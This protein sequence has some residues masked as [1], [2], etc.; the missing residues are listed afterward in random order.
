[1]KGNKE[2]SKLKKLPKL[3]KRVG[4]IYVKICD[5]KNIEKAIRKVCS[6][7]NA[8]RSKRSENGNAKKQKEK[9]LGNISY[10]TKMIQELL[11]EE[12]YKPK[13]LRRKEIF[14]GV[15]HKKRI[16]AKP[17]MIDKIVQNAVMQIIEPILTRHMYMYSCASIKKKGGTYC[18]RMIERAI[19]RKNR[20][21]KIYKNV[22]NTKYWIALDVVKFYDNILHCFL[23]FRLL[24]LFKDAKVLNLLFMSIDVYNVKITQAGKRGIPIGTPFGHWFANI[25][26]TPVDFVVKHIFKVKYM[27]RYAD[28]ILLF[29]SNKRKLKQQALFLQQALSRIG[30]S[31][32]SKLQVHQTTDKTTKDNRP[33]DFIGY[34]YYRDCTTLRSSICLRI[35]RRVRKV[36][37]KN[38]LNGHDARSIISYYGWIK[39]TDSWK[40]KVKYFSGTLQKAKEK[41]S[42]ESGKNQNRSRD[43]RRNIN[44]RNGSSRTWA[45]CACT[46]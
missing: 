11:I 18:K 44:R 30:L 3:P 1:M 25:M 26:L 12:R 39:N 7:P 10:Y 19:A 23:K 33:I 27:F 17:C 14:D 13:E 2:A 15:R 5:Y 40:L 31:I 16:I 41:I 37:K 6:S 21:G 43:R 28:D 22:K 35:T 32:K 29:G 38:V 45:V 8:T 34:R 42:S 9:Y 20:K 36:Q 4:G 46:A 24:K